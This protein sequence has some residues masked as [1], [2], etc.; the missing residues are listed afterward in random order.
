MRLYSRN[1][2]R[3]NDPK[4]YLGSDE[5]VKLRD[6]IQLI[7]YSATTMRRKDCN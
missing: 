6:Q 1:G 3:N 5:V 2:G 4:V 7:I